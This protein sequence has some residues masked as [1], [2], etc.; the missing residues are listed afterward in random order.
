VKQ[1]EISIYKI[2]AADQDIFDFTKPGDITR[3][4]TA[5]Q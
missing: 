3:P 5:E 4:V 2:M 1:N